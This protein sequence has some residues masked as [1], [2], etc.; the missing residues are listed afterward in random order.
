MYP[1]K[2]FN[3]P[4]ARCLVCLMGMFGF[5][6]QTANSQWVELET[7]FLMNVGCV[8]FVNK[9]IGWIL[10]TEARILKTEDGGKSWTEQYED[11]FCGLSAIHFPE[12][13]NNG[14]AAGSCYSPPEEFILKTT[15]GGNSWNEI[16]T[17]DNAVLMA[18]FFINNELGWGVGRGGTIVK[19]ADGGQTWEIQDSG[20]DSRLNDVYFL[21]ENQGWAVGRFGTIV[22]T[23]D[24]GNNW[25]NQ[26]SD[27]DIWLNGVYF[28]DEHTGWVAGGRWNYHLEDHEYIILRTKNGGATWES[29]KTGTGLSLSSVFFA[30]NHNGWMAGN[31]G[32]I[33]FTSDGGETWQEQ[34]SGTEWALSDMSF[35]NSGDGVYDGWIVGN[36]GTILHGTFTVVTVPKEESIAQDITLYQNFP[37]PFNP[38]TTIQFYIPERNWITIA[39]YDKLG[40]KIR[41]LVDGEYGKGLHAIQVDAAGLPSGVYL[42]RIR[43]ENHTQTKKLILMK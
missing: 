12:D 11:D 27:T 2:F 20:D 21:N 30:D 14:Y 32:T 25:H 3:S 22:Y 10:G 6:Q 8:S 33:L 31:F 34:E 4:T 15:D 42:Y 16:S 38:N 39:L 5:L 35:V 29:Q 28:V 17:G 9:D 1:F 41:T 7:N 37:N 18:L 23:S 36:I 24:G 19:T 26:E 13:E 40:R 43:S